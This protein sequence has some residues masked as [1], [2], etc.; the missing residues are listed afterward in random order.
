[1]EGVFLIFRVF[2]VSGREIWAAT[3]VGGASL[4]HAGKLLQRGR[5]TT[6]KY[7]R[8]PGPRQ[9]QRR[10][11][12]KTHKDFWIVALSFSGVSSA[13][14]LRSQILAAKPSK[15]LKKTRREPPARRNA[16]EDTI[17]CS[18]VPLVVSLQGVSWT[19]FWSFH[20]SLSQQPRDLDDSI[21]WRRCDHINL[22]RSLCGDPSEK[23]K[24]ALP[25]PK[26][27]LVDERSPQQQ[28]RSTAAPQQQ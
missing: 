11:R 19:I 18:A 25:V 22:E 26:P 13:A 28:Q 24:P 27:W 9:P 8:N 15:K 21:R 16:T 20:R 1:M 2:L 17:R 7:Q 12:W 23:K 6:D 4:F 10:T 14:L 3:F 5:P